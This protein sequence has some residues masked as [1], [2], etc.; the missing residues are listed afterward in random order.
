MN[1]KMIQ[2]TLLTKYFVNTLGRSTEKITQFLMNDTILIDFVI[3]RHVY[4]Y[5]LYTILVGLCESNILYSDQFIFNPQ[6]I[7][8]FLQ[9]SLVFLIFSYSIFIDFLLPFFPFLLFFIIILV[10]DLLFAA[11]DFY[12]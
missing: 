6:I 1:L 10:S 12:L 3:D 9:F 7:L 2:Y 5:Q 8:C 11:L 4:Q